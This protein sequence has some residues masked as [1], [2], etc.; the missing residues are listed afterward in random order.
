MARGNY[1]PDEIKKMSEL[2]LAYISHY[3]NLV[4]EEQQKFFTDALG[5]IWHRE[6]FLNKSVNQPQAKQHRN[7]VFMPLSQVIKP[8]VIN[9]IRELFGLTEEGKTKAP[10]I[11]GGE[12]APKKG[13]QIQSMDHFSKEDFKKMF[14]GR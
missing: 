10:H 9:T 14:G 11:G 5:I 4:V 2:D 6:D 8:D 12:Y 13:E 1:T 7:T 3:Q